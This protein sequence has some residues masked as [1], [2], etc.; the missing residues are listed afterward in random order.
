MGKRFGKQTLGRMIRRWRNN[1]EICLR[2]ITFGNVM[3]FNLEN[4]Q[5]L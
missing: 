3:R 4:F 1:I 5:T 2:E